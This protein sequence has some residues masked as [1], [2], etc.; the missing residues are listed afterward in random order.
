[1]NRAQKMA[2]FMLI[3]MS[4]SLLLTLIA[5]GILSYFFGT[6]IGH[7][8]FGFLGISGLAGLS[9]V[10]FKKD[11]GAVA[12]DERDQAI[13]LKS[14]MAGFGSCYGFFCIACMGIWGTLGFR[15][16]ISVNVLPKILIGGMFV[17]MI[18]Q[19]I[20]TLI[21]YGRGGKDGQK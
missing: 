14:A 21:G 19:S 16:T 5:F 11:K 20:T 8:G 18:V 2:W 4:T 7:A 15:A 10:I 12:F 1:M 9:P 6:K 3:V 13:H 17:A